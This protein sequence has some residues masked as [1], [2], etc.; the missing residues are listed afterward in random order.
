[1][2][3]REFRIKHATAGCV[4]RV[5]DTLLASSVGSNGFADVRQSENSEPERA[6]SA[7]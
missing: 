3:T 4:R 2:R 5:P 7:V 6:H 1:M